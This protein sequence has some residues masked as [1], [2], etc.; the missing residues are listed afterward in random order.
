MGTRPAILRTLY[1]SSARRVR[2]GSAR[3]RG[4]GRTLTSAAAMA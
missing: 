2:I 4:D 1:A 3:D